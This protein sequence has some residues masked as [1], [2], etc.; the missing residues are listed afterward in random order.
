MCSICPHFV[1]RF[2]WH[3]AIIGVQ[4]L[5]EDGVNFVDL[6]VGEVFI[7]GWRLLEGGVN[8]VYAVRI[9]SKICYVVVFSLCTY[10]HACILVSF[11]PLI[12]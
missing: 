5:L 7:E 4:C 10:Y 12:L 1:L 6:T 8:G 2:S 3:A 11:R 9:I